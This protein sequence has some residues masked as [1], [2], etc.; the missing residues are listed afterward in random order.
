MHIQLEIETDFKINS[1]S[2]LA[3][4]KQV[5]EHL[6]MKINK[7]RLARDIGVD[8]RTIDKYLNGFIPKTKRNKPSKIDE[9]YPIIASLL[10]EDSKQVFYYRRNLLVFKR[11][12][13]FRVWAIYIPYLYCQYA[14]I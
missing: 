12:P 11:Q 4:F 8:R 5:M 3:N 9:F 7:S 10:S 6:N 2:D 13:W 14:R 1:L